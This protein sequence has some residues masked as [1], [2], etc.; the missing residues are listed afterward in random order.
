MVDLTNIGTLFAFVL[1]CIA[2]PVLR[3]RDPQRVRPFRVPGGPYLV[4]V[5]GAA[6]CV[7]LMAYLPPLSWWRFVGWLTLGLAVY[8]AWGWMHSKL[9]VAPRSAALPL[10][11]AALGF[12]A[13]AIGMFLM[14]HDA[15]FV[16]VFARAAQGGGAAWGVGLLVA[17]LAVAAAGIAVT[18][19]RVA[20][21]ERS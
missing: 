11:V 15:G 14:P 10:D 13:A 20:R 18:R 7:M 19:G 9:R 6:A 21:A 3:R 16:G 4:P 2:I 8:C 12:V 1:V 5:I 17:G